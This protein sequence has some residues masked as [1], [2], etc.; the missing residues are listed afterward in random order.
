MCAPFAAVTQ[1]FNLAP[2]RLSHCW[3]ATVAVGCILPASPQPAALCSLHA[4]IGTPCMCCC[5]ADDTP[6]HTLL[7]LLLSPVSV[8]CSLT[9]GKAGHQ[10]GDEE[11]TAFYQH[12]HN[13]TQDWDQVSDESGAF[14]HLP[15]T[16]AHARLPASSAQV[17]D[18]AACMQSARAQRDPLHT[19]TGPHPHTSLTTEAD[20]RFP[21][22]DVFLML[23]LHSCRGCCLAEMQQTVRRCTHSTRPF[24][25]C[26]T[27][28]ACRLPL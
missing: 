12:Y 5:H 2:T 25:A 7:L 9:M 18:Q 17:S 6:Q 11:L 26:H 28:P 8:S 23:L 14:S 22:A 10:W 27:A 4:G 19:C 15:P 1:T 21:A 24:S 20:Q 16:T 13:T 3:S